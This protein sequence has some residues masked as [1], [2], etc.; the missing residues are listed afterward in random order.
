MTFPRGEK[1]GERKRRTRE[2]SPRPAPRTSH[3]PLRFRVLV[4]LALPL[5]PHR[6][7]YRRRG[8]ARARRLDLPLHAHR[9]ASG[10]RRLGLPLPISFPFDAS[11]AAPRLGLALPAGR[12]ARL[13]LRPAGHR[14]YRPSRP[15]QPPDKTERAASSQSEAALL[16]RP[17]FS[18]SRRRGQITPQRTSRKYCAFCGFFAAACAPETRRRIF[19]KLPFSGLKRQE[20]FTDWG[21]LDNR[22]CRWTPGVFKTLCIPKR[23]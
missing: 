17:R 23:E 1:V 20:P 15:A 13:P 8:L 21:F 16:W 10:A 3:L 5:H 6:R 12:T 22:S 2:R 14:H 18:T 11:R 19:C 9:A 7:D 4:G